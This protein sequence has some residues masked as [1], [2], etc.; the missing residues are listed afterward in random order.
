MRASDDSLTDSERRILEAIETQGLHVEHAEPAGE[1]PGFSYT[2]GLWH[3]F[4]QPEVIVFGL[5][6]HVAED[7]FDEIADLVHEGRRFLADSKHD[8]LLQ[9]YPAR[10]LAVPKGFNRE[11][12]G[13]A[14]WAHEGDGFEAV[15]LV[16]PDKQG[17][18][19]WDD[20]V[21]ASFRALQP[22]LAK[23]QPPA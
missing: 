14:V 21:R 10:F 8:G 19:P 15:Q 13:V 20:G 6:D 22:V 4:G 17:R 7:L 1:R 18:W 16:W 5:E 12:L 9:H 2:V 11:F 23:L 3:T